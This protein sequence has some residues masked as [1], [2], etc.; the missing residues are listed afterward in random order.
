MNW[1]YTFGKNMTVTD[2]HKKYWHIESYET[3]E[4]IKKGYVV[5]TLEISNI[6]N[7]TFL[8]RNSAY[9]VGTIESAIFNWTDGTVSIKRYEEVYKLKAPTIELNGST[10][11]QYTLKITNPNDPLAPTL[12]PTATFY[13]QN[14]GEITYDIEPGK[15][16]LLDFS[17]SKDPD[18][19]ESITYTGYFAAFHCTN[20]DNTSFVAK[21]TVAPKDLTC[22]ATCVLDETTGAFKYVTYTITNPNAYAIILTGSLKL[23]DTVLKTN[24]EISANGSIS[25]N[26]TTDGYQLS[27]EGTISAKGE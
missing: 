6:D 10:T 21:K 16:I 4:A 5:D 12:A 26:I 27:L 13:C 23:D 18:V 15:Y 2:Q 1:L 17:W 8:K 20:S 22:E 3:D 25:D 24:F 7:S 9:K 14:L 11:T 19:E